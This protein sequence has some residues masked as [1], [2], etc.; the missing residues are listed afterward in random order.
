MV[1]RNTAPHTPH[2]QR[3][4]PLWADSGNISTFPPSVVAALCHR[5]QGCLFRPDTQRG[6]QVHASVTSATPGWPAFSIWSRPTSLAPPPRGTRQE[7]GFPIAWLTEPRRFE[8]RNCVY[9]HCDTTRIV[10]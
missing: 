5:A 9:G 3:L 7:K 8:L 2:G 4:P 10:H 6:Q 1:S